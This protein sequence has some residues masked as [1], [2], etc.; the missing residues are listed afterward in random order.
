MP[1]ARGP[2]GRGKVTVDRDY[3]DHESPAGTLAIFLNNE[4]RRSDGLRPW[5]P[6]R[7]A[8]ASGPACRAGP[9]A[10]HTGPGR[11]AGMHWQCQ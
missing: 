4:V 7:L 6:G 5:H 3:H 9:P 10:V 11:E 8:P 1:P 2:G